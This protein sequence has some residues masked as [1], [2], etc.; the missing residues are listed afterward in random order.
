MNNEV[1]IWKDIPGY[2]GLY[3]SS[4]LGN[5]KSLSRPCV[6][7][8]TKYIRKEK[9][10]SPTLSNGYKVVTLY[11][12]ENDNIIRKTHKVSII[13]AMCFLDHKS[14]GQKFVVDHINNIKTDDRLVNL[15]ILTNRQNVS[16]D[17]KKTK[18]CTSKYVG[19][20]LRSD[21]KA[22]V[23]AIG[24]NW[25]MKHLGS[26]KSEYEAYQAYLKELN[27]ILKNSHEKL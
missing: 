13:V 7:S 26:F 22:W 19:V 10:I 23:A 11:R 17:I 2:E 21:G 4:N 18:K 9:I 27:K 3:Q 6:N 12:N 14:A 16:K 15:Q 25:K 5:V 1:E 20:S 8:I 24:I